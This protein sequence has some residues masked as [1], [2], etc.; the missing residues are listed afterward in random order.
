MTTSK[1]TKTVKT[2]DTKTTEQKP[3][4]ASKVEVKATKPVKAKKDLTKRDVVAVISKTLK[5]AYITTAVKYSQTAKAEELLKADMKKRDALAGIAEAK[6]FEF[7]VLKANV[8]LDEA[9]NTK[10]SNHCDY[11]NNGYEMLSSKGKNVT[12]ESTIKAKPAEIKATEK[13]DKTKPVKS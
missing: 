1:S 13:A 4:V 10:F 6:D 11:V 12:I 5:Q 8:T 9:Q 7:K 3:A 2:T